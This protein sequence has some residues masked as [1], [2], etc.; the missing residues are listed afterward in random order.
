[1]FVVEAA[2]VGGG[3]LARRVVRR[4][5]VDVVGSFIFGLYYIGIIGVGFI[6]FES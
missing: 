3:R 2:V 6:S 5:V 1:V 4:M